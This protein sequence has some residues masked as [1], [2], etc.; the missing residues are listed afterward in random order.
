MSDGVRALGAFGS[1]SSLGGER[2]SRDRRR[3]CPCSGSGLG[4]SDASSAQGQMAESPLTQKEEKV[5][6]GKN[7]EDVMLAKDP[8]W[9]S[10]PTH[11]A[12]L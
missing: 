2:R 8:A 6:M 1:L 4:G 5:R 7:R 10:A 3:S 12:S 9:P 11:I